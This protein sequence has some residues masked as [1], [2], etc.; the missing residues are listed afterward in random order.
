MSKSLSPAH[1]SFRY[2]PCSPLVLS[3]KI[4]RP[5][6]VASAQAGSS[7]GDGSACSR[8][9]SCRHTRRFS[10]RQ[11]TANNHSEAIY[12]MQL[13]S[14]ASYG[15]AEALP[16]LHTAIQHEL[17]SFPDR[18]LSRFTRRPM[19]QAALRLLSY[20]ANVFRVAAFITT[21]SSN[22]LFPMRF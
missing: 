13:S 18:G 4:V 22:A 19:K 6:S 10:P 2:A 21:S 8:D 1:G 12:R 20:E 15:C 16:Q 3:T 9:A 5:R 7:Q 14:V 17:V 11:A